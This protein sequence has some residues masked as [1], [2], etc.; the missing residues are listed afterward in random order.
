MF[1][2]EYNN[3]VQL[4][5]EI[6]RGGEARI[7]SIPGI[8]EVAKI[9]HKQPISPQK[10]EKLR[11][12][13][14]INNDQLKTFTALPT[15]LLFD[16][17]RKRLAGFTMPYATGKLPIFQLIGPK[18]RKQHFPDKDYRFLCS[19]ALNT[20][21]AFAIL[22]T[23]GIIV[24][25][26]N[27]SGLL[28][29]S[30]GRVFVI[31]CDSFQ[32]RHGGKAFLCEVGVPGFTPPELQ[33]K[34]SQI[35]RTIQHDCFGLAVLIFQLLF[36]GRHPFVGR[37][38]GAG[39]MPMERAIAEY[40]FAF[41][42]RPETQMLPPPESLL[43]DEVGELSK[44]FER[45]FLA[46]QHRTEAPEWV[47]ALNKF[48]STLRHCSENKSHWFP[49]SAK[50]CP[51]CG[52]ENHSGLLLFALIST[53]LSGSTETVSIATLWAAI[54]AV[55]NYVAE[56]FPTQTAS[57]RPTAGAQ[58][59]AKGLL[60]QKITS[61]VW[62]TISGVGLLILLYSGSAIC[63]LL[64]VI[65]LFFG[66]KTFTG[67]KNHPLT[68]SLK[69]E[70][71][72]ISQQLAQMKEQWE[73]NVRNL[74][75]LV[76][77]EKLR[78]AKDELAL[79]PAKRL[80]ELRGLE[81]SKRD[82]QLQQFLEAFSI[83]DASIDGIGKGRKMTLRAY[84]VYTAA[85]I[86]PY[87][88]IPGF[89]PKSM[90]SLRAWRAMLESQFIFDPRKSVEQSFLSKVEQ[91]YRNEFRRLGMILET[92]PVK[93]RAIRETSIH[94]EQEIKRSSALLLARYGQIKADLKIL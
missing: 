35:E 36:M 18:S 52:I 5:P 29:G 66:F 7:A 62:L 17:S 85:D 81:S 2:D 26:V 12:L 32:I 8:A 55:P 73:N 30:D 6:G 45:S 16:S 64:I 54:E 39:E 22:H 65:A 25:D 19:V 1:F 88:K 93:L 43:L 83:A 53:K 40:R 86:R 49:A 80:K 76:E 87:L 48:Q 75:F 23:Q 9:Y 78:A 21:K 68:K 69:A 47:T 90:G 38:I 15:R 20:A 91:K 11:L 13:R 72:Q 34:G 37:F 94:R 74:D 57:F 61:L 42:G 50:N 70:D 24:G 14:T 79:V 28:V 41:A 89:G 77:K 51:W 60:K 44:L 58:Q 4:G 56:P 27:E 63:L 31:D 84:S 46:K 10:D 92:G 3:L 71:R 33:A 82:H 67:I 59:A